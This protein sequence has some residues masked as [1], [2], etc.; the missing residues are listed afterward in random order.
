MPKDISIT[1]IKIKEVSLVGDKDDIKEQLKQIIDEF[2]EKKL[3]LERPVEIEITELNPNNNLQ[4]SVFTEDGDEFLC[5]GD[6]DEGIED[7][8]VMLSLKKKA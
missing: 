7:N 2:D 4:T 3:T 6:Q 1:K 8:W 5:V